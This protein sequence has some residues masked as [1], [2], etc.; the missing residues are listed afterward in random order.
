MSF[1][2]YSQPSPRCPREQW[3]NPHHMAG[4]Q[5]SGQSR[6]CL[7]TKGEKPIWDV[8]Y[9][10]GGLQASRGKKKQR[11]G[12]CTFLE[13][14]PADFMGFPKRFRP[15]SLGRQ[16]IILKNYPELS[17]FLVAGRNYWMDV[18]IIKLSHLETGCCFP[19]LPAIT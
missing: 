9:G 5:D 16:H 11:N 7:E 1:S 8:Q 2:K 15:A 19:Q 3:G 18:I 13:V 6:S 14:G 10:G 4:T 12:Q 17:I